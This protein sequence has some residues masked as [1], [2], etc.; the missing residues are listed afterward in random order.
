MGDFQVSS[1]QLSNKTN[2]NAARGDEAGDETRG[3]HAESNTLAISEPRP[4]RF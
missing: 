3:K 2:L 1:F 4:G